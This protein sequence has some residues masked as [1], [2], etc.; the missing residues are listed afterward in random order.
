MTKRADAL[1]FDVRRSEAVT[2]GLVAAWVIGVVRQ[3]EAWAGFCSNEV[4]FGAFRY[5]C[6]RIGEPYIASR[7]ISNVDR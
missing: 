7:H 6:S 4:I 1:A 5:S 3:I 2:A